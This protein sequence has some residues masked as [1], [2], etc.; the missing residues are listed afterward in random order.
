MQQNI[1]FSDARIGTIRPPPD[2]RREAEDR[3]VTAEIIAAEILNTQGGLK[4]MNDLKA[5]RDRPVSIDASRVR[6]VGAQA[7]QVLMAARAAWQADGLAFSITAR[8]AD[9]QLGLKALGA[10][11]DMLAGQPT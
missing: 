6:H 4:L 2:L 7:L 9:L 1:R 5:V 3:I 10:P 8:S 11:G